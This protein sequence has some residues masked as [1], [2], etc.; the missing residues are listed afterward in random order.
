MT[1]K[2]GQK[3]KFAD[4]FAG[5]G[6]FNL[7]LRQLGHQCVFA[8]EID[9]ALRELYEQNFG[10]MPAGDIREVNVKNIPSHDILCAGF[11]CQPFSKAGQQDGLGDPELGEL[12]KY[13]IK[14]MRHHH[15]RFLILENV[16]NFEMHDD[17][18]TW[19]RIRNLLSREGYTVLIKSFRHIS[20]ASHRFESE[21]ILWEVRK[22]LMNL[23]GQIL[24]TSVRQ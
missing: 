11:P 8:S 1:Q 6:G 5:L 18:Q 15:P 21:C 22:T 24:S 20:L 12:Y 2:K 17:R 4:L 13:I 14:V 23:S 7:A 10:I 9:A 19:N 16:P 3:M